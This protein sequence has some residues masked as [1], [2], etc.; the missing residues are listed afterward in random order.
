MTTAEDATIAQAKGYV[1]LANRMLE[2]AVVR[3]RREGRT[4]QSIG[5][6]LGVTHQGARSR[7]SK[8]VASANG[9]M[10]ESPNGS[11]VSSDHARSDNG[12]APVGAGDGLG[13][14]V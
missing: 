12:D 8:V 13:Y 6:E 10:P 14:D 11:V 1:D 2:V 7:W 4:W 9:H 3:A 5:S